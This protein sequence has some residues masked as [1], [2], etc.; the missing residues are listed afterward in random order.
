MAGNAAFTTVPSRKATPDPRTAAASTQRP[1]AVAKATSWSTGCTW[2]PYGIRAKKRAGAPKG[3]RRG[4][5]GRR[6]PD[7]SPGTR[8]REP[9]DAHPNAF[10]PNGKPAT[11]QFQ[12]I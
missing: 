7:V 8:W 5:T 11:V 6:I 10:L 9:G 3:R 12:E 1:R 4:D 2:S